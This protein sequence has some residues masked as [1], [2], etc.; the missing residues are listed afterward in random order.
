[1]ITTDDMKA[2]GLQTNLED[3][4]STIVVVFRVARLGR[5]HRAELFDDDEELW[6]HMITTHPVRERMRPRV[7]D[8][9]HRTK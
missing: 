1:M 4:P 5:Y 3:K 7:T 9:S 6:H 2:V 8:E